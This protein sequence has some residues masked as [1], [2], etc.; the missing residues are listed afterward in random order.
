MSST[1]GDNIKISLF[2]ESHGKAIGIVIDGLDPGIQLDLEE[3]RMEMSRRA[4]GK[5]KISTSRREKDDFE[6]LSGYFQD[7]TTGTPLCAMIENTNT[8]SRDYQKTKDLLRPGHADFTGI[9]RYQGHNDY[10][11]GGHFSGRLT[12]SLCFA[13]AIAKQILKSKGILVGSHLK[14]IG[15]VEDEDFN[16]TEISLELLERLKTSKIPTITRGKSSEMEEVILD[17]KKQG[18]SIGGIVELAVLDL[19]PGI[20]SPFFDSIES[21]ISAMVFSVPGV[22][23]IEFGAGFHM[24]SMKGSQAND[25]F[26]IEDSLVKTYTNNN[27][28]ILGGISSGMPILFKVALKPTPSIGKKQRTV[29]IKKQENTSIE[30]IG[31]HD[32]S[33]V[34]R[35]LPVLEA[36][37]ALAIL[38]LIM[39]M[40]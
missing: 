11:G 1:W 22:K 7:K 31:R 34:V 12:A 10:R 32:P 18:D 13:G 15:H 40:K 28:G 39:E 5:D 25:E 6:I 36:A 20:G 26:Y 30:I 23:A 27:G 37:T 2:G 29:D 19:A 8:K 14:S 38:D 3:I 9:K 24:A 21:K 16:R 35:A 4:P 17:A 33:I